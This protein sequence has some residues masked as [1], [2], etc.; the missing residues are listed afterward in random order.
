[1][2]ERFSA[3]GAAFDIFRNRGRAGVLTGASVA[4]LVGNLLILSV[5]VVLAWGSLATLGVAYYDVLTGAFEGKPMEEPND[6]R[7]AALLQALAGVAGAGV[8]LLFLV[9]LLL[10]AYEA[11]IHRWLVRGEAGGGVFG[12]TLGADTWRVYLCY[13]VWF[14]VYIALSIAVGVAASVA[15]GVLGAALAA[16]QVDPGVIALIVFPVFC[17]FYAAMIY[18]L[19]RL[20]PATAVTVGLR[21]FAFFEA[22]TATRDRFWAMLGAFL[23]I[24]LLYLAVYLAVFSVGAVA[25]L[26]PML[27]AFAAGAAPDAATFYAAMFAPGAL[28]VLVGLYLIMLAVGVICYIAFMGVNA[29]AARA[30]IEEGRFGPPAAP[31]AAAPVVS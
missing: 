7:V 15:A 8:I 23:I 18:V 31:A 1:M 14:F 13:W 16:A 9:Y 11:A 10:A 5:F 2:T 12:L 25:V 20:A 22:W 17:A 27:G 21:R 26:G 6:P 30:A 4:Y 24:I 3:G 19:V 29:R 28:A